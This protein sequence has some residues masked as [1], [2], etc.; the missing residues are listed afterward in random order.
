MNKET[1]I[2]VEFM[3]LSKERYQFD[4]EEAAEE[5]YRNFK[6]ISVEPECV[7]AIQTCLARKKIFEEESPLWNEQDTRRYLK[8]FIIHYQKLRGVR[9][10]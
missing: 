2:V 5:V 4:P 10:N 6:K 9:N 3:Y 1:G 7:A 8:K